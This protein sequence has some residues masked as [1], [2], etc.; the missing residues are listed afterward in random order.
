MKPTLI[1]GGIGVGLLAFI[2]YR[3]YKDKQQQTNPPAGANPSTPRASSTPAVIPASLPTTPASV[4][5]KTLDLE[6]FLRKGM[7]DGQGQR[8]IKKLQFLLGVTE[9]GA[10]GSQTEAALT[11]VAQQGLSIGYPLSIYGKETNLGAIWAFDG[12]TTQRKVDADAKYPVTAPSTAIAS[13]SSSW[14][15]DWFGNALPTG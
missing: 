15:Y 13:G 12:I 7:R 5:P 11:R 9:D 8:E 10:F 4:A 2:L 1:L 3:M 14:F 6:L